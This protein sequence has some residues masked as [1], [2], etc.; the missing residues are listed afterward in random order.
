V[1]EDWGSILFIGLACLL[2][3]HSQLFFV[4]TE[5]GIQT[6]Q[7]RLLFDGG[8][9]NHTVGGITVM[10]WQLSRTHSD[11]AVDRQTTHTRVSQRECQPI[12]ER[13]LELQSTTSFKPGDLP[14]GHGADGKLIGTRN[15]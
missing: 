8:R 15:V 6:Y 1:A 9:K 14:A 5:S 12:V 13:G 7:C 10:F 2:D 11:C 3:Q 4:S